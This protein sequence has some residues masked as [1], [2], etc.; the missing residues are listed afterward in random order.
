[1]LKIFESTATWM[2]VQNP[3]QGGD[4]EYLD[5]LRFIEVKLQALIYDVGI[6]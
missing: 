3:Q 1:M 6:A 4:P 5:G 2:Y